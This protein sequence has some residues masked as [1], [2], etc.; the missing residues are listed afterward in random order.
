MNIHHGVVNLVEIVGEGQVFVHLGCN[1]VN[2]GNN[3][4]TSCSHHLCHQ[5]VFKVKCDIQKL[6]HLHD[7]A[8]RITLNGYNHGL[9]KVNTRSLPH[10]WV[11][12]DFEA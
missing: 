4:N 8:V 2:F 1:F 10:L 3:T 6:V 5:H 11:S 9:L 7:P 12:L